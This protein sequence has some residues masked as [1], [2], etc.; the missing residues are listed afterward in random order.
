[1]TVIYMHNDLCIEFCKCIRM[2]VCII[3][4]ISGTYV[5]ILPTPK[6]SRPLTGNAADG[7]GVG[8]DE[9]TAGRMASSHEGTVA[10]REH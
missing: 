8:D 10:A 2:Q 3:I 1:M 6:T 4:I 9:A 7:V 5:C